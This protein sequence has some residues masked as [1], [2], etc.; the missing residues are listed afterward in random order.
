MTIRIY[1]IISIIILPLCT[2]DI[3]AHEL[4]KGY[5]YIISMKHFTGKISSENEKWAPK[6][7]FIKKNKKEILTFTEKASSLKIGMSQNEVLNLL[8]VPTIT[9]KSSSKKVNNVHIIIWDYYLIKK[10]DNGVNGKFDVYLMLVFSSDKILK[11][12]VFCKGSAYV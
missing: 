9:Q 2:K 6:S 5:E 3:L 1:I 12:V 11:E 10:D 7:F 4:Q 8:G